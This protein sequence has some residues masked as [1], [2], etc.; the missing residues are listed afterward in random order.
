[1]LRLHHVGIVVND[2]KEAVSKYCHVLGLDERTITVNRG[3]YSTADGEV[4]EFEYAFLPS[5]GGTMIELVMPVS[6]GP[7]MRYLRK[8][9]EGLFH[10]AFEAEDLKLAVERFKEAGIPVAGVTPTERLVSVFF[11]PKHAHGVLIQL[12]KKGL[13]LPDGR[14]NP[15]ALT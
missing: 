15:E 2:L 1:M 3:W 8:K 12:V 14:I 7:T 5:G 4:E 13:F 10:L 6:E 9:G 11:H